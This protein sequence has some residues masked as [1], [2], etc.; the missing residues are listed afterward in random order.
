M[1]PPT[2]DP[3]QIMADQ[4]PNLHIVPQTPQLQVFCSL[5]YV[6]SV[7]DV[8]KGIYTTLRDRTSQRREFIF[9][10]DRLATFLIE[11]ALEFVPAGHKTVKTPVGIEY[12][13]RSIN[14]V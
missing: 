7:N 5:A 8:S 13:G 3:S 11:K 6:L 12:D 2:P 1:N 4:L 9:N 14:T 10:V